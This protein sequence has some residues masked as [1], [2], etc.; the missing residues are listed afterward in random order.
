MVYMCPQSM[1][2]SSEHGSNQHIHGDVVTLSLCFL[3]LP[4][5]SLQRPAAAEL[6]AGSILT[7]DGAHPCPPSPAGLPQVSH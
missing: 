3:Q 5:A 7:G 2:L 6:G 1:G 4:T